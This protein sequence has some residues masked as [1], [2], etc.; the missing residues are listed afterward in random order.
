MIISSELSHIN[1]LHYLNIGIEPVSLGIVKIFLA[2]FIKKINVQ[3]LNFSNKNKFF[4]VT[5]KLSIPQ[6]YF[7][8]DSRK[9]ILPGGNFI[10]GHS[11]VLTCSKEHFELVYLLSAEFCDFFFFF[12]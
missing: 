6:I 7:S 5:A 11:G 10:E 1:E 4:L 2:I 12:P 3:K 8:V 9:K